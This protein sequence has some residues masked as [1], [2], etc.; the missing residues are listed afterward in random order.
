MVIALSLFILSIGIEVVG[1]LTPL[2]DSET[3]PDH[4]VIIYV[5]EKDVV[6]SEKKSAVP[7]PRWEWQEDRQL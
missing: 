5:D 2:K 7:S 4:F 1:N 6:E 3:Q